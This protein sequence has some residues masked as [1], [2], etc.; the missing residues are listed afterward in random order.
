MHVVADPHLTGHHHL[1]AGRRAARDADLRANQIVLAQSTVVA[2]HHQIVELRALAN[3]GRAIRAPIDRGASA[4]FHVVADFHVAKLRGQLVSPFVL[5]VAETIGADHRAG[6]DNRAIANLRL[7]VQHHVGKHRDVAS[8]HA[9]GHDPR[10]RVDR[11]ARADHHVVANH[12]Q[13]MHVDA[14]GQL[15]GLADDRIRAEA[16][17]LLGAAGAK[18]LDDLGERFVDVVD[19]DCGHAVALEFGR[20]HRGRGRRL[21]QPRG[22]F[23]AVGQRDLSRSGHRQD[24]SVGNLGRWIA[25]QPAAYEFGKLRQGGRHPRVLSFKAADRGWAVL[26]Q[27]IDETSKRNGCLPEGVGGP[28]EAG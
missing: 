7:F 27:H 20:N 8:D 15:R 1:V 11:R 10:A 25:A 24:G 16:R 5:A 2:D 18:V 19:L 26:C 13:R 4:D 9:T 3:R 14:G 22:A 28:W 23:L 17:A 6:V 21:R 12:R